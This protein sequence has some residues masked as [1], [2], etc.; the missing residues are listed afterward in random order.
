MRWQAFRRFCQ[1]PSPQ[2][3]AFA[4]CTAHSRTHCR[5]H[6]DEGGEKE[7]GGEGEGESDGDGALADAA[8]D[9]VGALHAAFAADSGDSDAAMERLLPQVCLSAVGTAAAA[10]AVGVSGGKARVRSGL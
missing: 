6:S 1:R 3:S 7:G 8:G 2:G 9:L 5:A 4:Q 10:G